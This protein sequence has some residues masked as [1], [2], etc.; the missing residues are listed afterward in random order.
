MTWV[1]FV[2]QVEHQLEQLSV[3]KT[4]Y[5]LDYIGFVSSDRNH[6][7]TVRIEIYNKENGKYFSI[8]G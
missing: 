3:D 4:S 7:Q 5:E 8:E 1:E 6:G 2:K